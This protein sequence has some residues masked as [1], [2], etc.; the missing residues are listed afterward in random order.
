MENI[1]EEDIRSPLTGHDSIT[2]IN[3]GS[4]FHLFKNEVFPRPNATLS[5]KNTHEPKFK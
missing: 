3:W 2:P 4:V 5:D 1:K